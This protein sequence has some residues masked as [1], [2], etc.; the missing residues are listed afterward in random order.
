MQTSQVSSPKSGSVRHESFGAATPCSKEEILQEWQSAIELLDVREREMS[1]MSK[2]FIE[3]TKAEKMEKD[4]LLQANQTMLEESRRRG[5]H[6][7]KLEAF[8]ASCHL[9]Y[10]LQQPIASAFMSI[11]IRMPWWTGNSEPQEPSYLHTDVA[12]AEN[13]YSRLKSAIEANDQLTQK[14]L[15]VQAQHEAEMES[16]HLH[17]KKS[18][19][20][21]QHQAMISAALWSIE[22]L[23]LQSKIQEKETD[24]KILNQSINHLLKQGMEKLYTQNKASSQAHSMDHQ[25]K[26]NH[27]ITMPSTDRSLH[28]S[29]RVQ[30]LLSPRTPRSEDVS[31]RIP[32]SPQNFGGSQTFVE[33]KRAQQQ[34]HIAGGMHE[35]I[36]SPVGGSALSR[37]FSFSQPFEEHAPLQPQQQQQKQ[38]QQQQQ[39]YMTGDTREGF[40]GSMVASALPRNVEFSQKFEEHAHL[41]LHAHLQQFERQIHGS[42]REGPIYSI[43]TPTSEHM[44]DA[45][46]NIEEQAQVQQKTPYQTS[47]SLQKGRDNSIADSSSP[48][49]GDGMTSGS[50]RGLFVSASPRVEFRPKFDDFDVHAHVH[51]QFQQQQ[52][53]HHISDSGS[54]GGSS[55]SSLQQRY[56]QAVEQ[57]QQQI[58]QR[59]QLEIP[60]QHLP[61][62]PA[63]DV[64]RG[65]KGTKICSEFRK[66]LVSTKPER[67]NEDKEL[68]QGAR[69]AAIEL[70]GPS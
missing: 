61:M 16:L 41:Q 66:L 30:S 25:P 33:H 55:I 28:V 65:L 50:R 9:P 68:P 63:A 44:V 15:D 38:Q 18:I 69:A 59:M 4:L 29:E 56:S 32:D 2:D 45:S 62:Q 70:K 43:V 10:Y 27:P 6:L 24:A 19:D 20:L 42:H 34:Q 39:Q 5:L 60:N 51:Q 26:I 46:Q 47:S 14:S 53:W 36:S 37:N 58:L 67:V 54:E 3:Y 35:K 17:H 64:S 13:V 1:T 8:F 22:R 57:Q 48:C 52:L 23:T 21:V 7:K 40:F 49:D 12:D 11:G 31:I